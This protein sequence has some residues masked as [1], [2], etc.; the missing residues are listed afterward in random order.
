MDLMRND[1][2]KHYRE[3]RKILAMGRSEP[4]D[5]FQPRDRTLLWILIVAGILV[6]GALF[7]GCEKPALAYTD[8]QAIQVIVGE[9]SNQGYK[10]MVFVGEVLR[11]KGSIRGFYG[12]HASHSQKEPAWV[13]IMAK[14]AWDRSKLTNFTQ[15]ATH[16][17]NIH[18]FGTPYWVK[19][20][21]LTFEYK[22]HKF[23]REVK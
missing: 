1:T 15:N 23:Y 5:E 14:K 3:I 10:G 20:C 18:A 22:D 11:H 6:F 4:L 9:A 7:I 17:E 2:A 8:K 21:K 13:W 16:F 12:L 19:K